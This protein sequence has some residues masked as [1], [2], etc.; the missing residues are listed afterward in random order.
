MY[1][2]RTV[3]LQSR[4]NVL[5]ILARTLA[6]VQS[7][8]TIMSAPVILVFTERAAKVN[9][10]ALINMTC[11][12]NALPR[13]PQEKPQLI[14]ILSLDVN[15]MHLQNLQLDNMP[16]LPLPRTY[17]QVH[18]FTLEVATSLSCI[19]CLLVCSPMLLLLLLSREDVLQRFHF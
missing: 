5:Q 17:K 16:W 7:Y 1:T 11:R 4:V 8:R 3:C 6:N 2:L 13:S 12:N 19:F 10:L 15:N 9:D 14:A 18:S